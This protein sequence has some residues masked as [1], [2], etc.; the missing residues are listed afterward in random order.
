MWSKVNHVV[1]GGPSLNTRL[2]GRARVV[3]MGA[4][5]FVQNEA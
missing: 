1:D 4:A 5:V 2:P 3:V